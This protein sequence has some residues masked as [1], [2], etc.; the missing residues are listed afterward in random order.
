MESEERAGRLPNVVAIVLNWNG[1]ADT[2]RCVESLQKVVYAILSIV[3]VD[4]GSSDGSVEKLSKHFPELLIL[5]LQRNGGYGAG[6]NAGIRY[7]L[8]H[9]ADYVLILNNDTVVSPHFLMPLVE[10]LEARKNLG[11]VTGRVHYLSHQ[12]QLFS[13]AGRISRLL[14]TGLNK[15]GLFSRSQKPDEGRDINYICGVMLLVKRP[16]FEQV[17][18]FDEKYF[19]YFEDLEFSQRVCR[20][21]TMRYVPTSLLYHKSGGGKGWRSYTETYLYYHTRN[22]FL[23]FENESL[24]YRGYVSLFS[25][26]VSV[27]KSFFILMNIVKDSPRARR[28]LVSLWRGLRDGVMLYLSGTMQESER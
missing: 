23:A 24:L 10:T 16:V 11:V 27:G 5:P 3:I 18:F 12:E 28:Q 14:C 15:G 19:M 21:F 9:G 22:R 6:N 26:A 7:A 20:Q 1:C 4:N 2:I 8:D 25:V 17:G 13:G